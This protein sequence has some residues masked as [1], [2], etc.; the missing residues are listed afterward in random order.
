MTVTM[1]MTVLCDLTQYSLVGVSQ[2]FRGTYPSILCPKDGAAGYSQMLFSVYQT[3]RDHLP[4]DG[5]L[6]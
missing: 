2:C 6:N 5:Y 3:T 4:E 1:K